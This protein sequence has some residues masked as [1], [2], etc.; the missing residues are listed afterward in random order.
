[1]EKCYIIELME[2]VTHNKLSQ[3]TQAH[4]NQLL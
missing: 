4:L 2:Q 1:M 3:T